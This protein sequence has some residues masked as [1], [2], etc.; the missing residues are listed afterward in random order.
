MP[1][2]QAM[3]PITILTTLAE[4]DIEMAAVGQLIHEWLKDFGVPITWK[5]MAFGNLLNHIRNVRDF[6]MFIL[7]WRSLPIDPDYLKRFFHSSNEYPMGRH[8][9][10]YNDSEF[11]RMA[12]LQT[13]ELNARARRK[14]VRDLQSKLMADLPYIPLYVPFRLEGI[15]IDRFEGWTTMLGGVGNTWTFC[16]IRPIQK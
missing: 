1:S 14:I 5:P 3:S 16:L 11:D 6:D 9:T 12:D 10:G 2:G 4:Y 13:R 8:Y 7:G 15:R